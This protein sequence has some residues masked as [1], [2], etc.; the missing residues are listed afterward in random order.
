MSLWAEIKQ[1]RITQIF[2]GYMAAGWMLLAVVDQ[3][4][5]R[6]ILP[7]LFYTVSLT[8]YLFGGL[9]AL[10]IG[11]Y[12]GEKGVQKAPAS[13]I[14][15]LVLLGLACIGTSVQ[16]VRGGLAEITLADALAATGAD[17]TS[18]GVL[19]FEDMSA[20]GSITAVADGIT[21]GLI[22]ALARVPELDVTSRNAA[23]QV[24]GLDVPADSIAS[25]LG[26]GILIEGTVVQVA[27]E[28]RVSVQVLE[29]DTGLQL[30]RE[31]FTWPAADLATVGDQLAGEVANV[32]R[33][34]IGAE[35]RLRQGRAAAPNSAAWLQVARAERSLKEASEGVRQG[36]V[37]RVVAA[38]D[39]AESELQKARES[40][41]QWAEPLV[42]LGQVAY[43]RYVV[44]TSIEELVGRLDEGVSFANQA[45]ALQPDHAGALELRGIARYRRWL[46]AGEE[47]DT[48]F[49]A[50]R[51]DL[52]RAFQLDRTRASAKS[53]LSHLYYQVSDWPQAVLA[54]RDAYAL[55][56]FLS[57]A[58][59][60]LWRLYAASYDLGEH[61]E[62]RRWCMEGRRRFPD[63]YRFVQCEIFL[64]T[65][66]QAEPD[67]EEAW[68]LHEELLALVGERP[69]F[70]DAQAQM[71]IGGVIG[72]AG[73][74]DSANAVFQRA[75]R[76]ADV[77][78]EG[79][80]MVMEATMRSV[81]GD[82]EGSISV[83][84]RYMAAHPGHF[85][86]PH[87][88][89]RNVEGEPAFQRLRAGS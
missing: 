66:A 22:G 23:Q 26:V 13:E 75:R 42:L 14:V 40:A 12:H 19:Y 83:L 6:E 78:P 36:D 68:N 11:W 82:V 25:I 8:V 32:L 51:D 44:A 34:Q 27:E 59:G 37:E 55:D 10:I 58:D 85:P 54:A 77:D 49:E 67:V 24:R 39:A 87:W 73:L 2:V 69:E 5:D 38:F 1:R 47:V 56:A 21:E 20:D 65:M 17:L 62:A 28:L 84:Q 80:L 35:I 71:V 9:A 33:E 61:A 29:G 46:T 15:V 18:I 52:E 64:L 31:N 3:F 63:N 88:W 4:V 48:L 72:R 30:T 86:G 89:W 57:V 16:V 74:A 45:L 43:E 53:T 79:E 41:P 50:A 60:V 7:S 81:I 70:Y 76:D